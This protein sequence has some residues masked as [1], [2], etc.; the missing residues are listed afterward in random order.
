ML[1]LEGIRILDLTRV[2]PGPFCTMTLGDLGA[3][4]IKIEAPA[5]A[6][7]RRQTGTFRSPSEADRREAAFNPID[8]NKKSLALN[9]RSGDGRE[10][11]YR[12]V[13][14]ADVMVEA[15]RPGV[16]KR[17]KIDYQTLSQINPR[18]IG[19]SITGYGQDGPYRNM[20]GHEANFVATGGALNL[21]GEAG[22]KPV[23]PLTLVADRGGSAMQA[24]I[25]ILSAI[26]ARN[27]TGRGQY[28]DIAIMDSVISLMVWPSISYFYHGI[29]P[30]RGTT[31]DQGAYPYYGVYKTLD[32]KYITIGCIEPWLWEKFCR[33]IGKEEF[34]PYHFKTEHLVYPPD[35]DKWSEI[36]A[37]L[38]Q[39]FLTRTRDEWFETLRRK[40]I[41]VGKVNTLDEVFADK[42]VKHRK[43]LI[44]IDDPELGTIRQ[45]GIATKLSETPGKVRS[46]APTF[47][48]HTREILGRLGYNEETV[49]QFYHDKIIS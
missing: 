36:S 19:C 42:Q 18:L 10:I 17:L 31:T 33:E 45:V 40:D 24:T 43:M 1:A 48:Q 38:D 34:I 32:N 22:R 15:F 3:E 14:N 23:I 4:V 49:S 35:G 44:E 2:G 30:E 16:A 12:L 11:F 46:L 5:E 47:G 39:L 26:I 25:G 20:A 9:L 13:E 8:R 29:V 41:P 21:I 27:Q 7:D 6:G 28:I 37:Y